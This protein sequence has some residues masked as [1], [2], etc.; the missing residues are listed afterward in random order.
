MNVGLDHLDG[1]R[2]LL[3][4]VVD[5]PDRRRLVQPVVDPQD[6]DPG[7]IVDRGELVVLLARALERR[8]ELDVDLD[9]VTGL[10][11]LVALPPIHVSAVALGGREPV[12]VQ[13]LEDPPHARGAYLEVVVRFRYIEIFRGPK[14]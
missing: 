12:H 13:A 4:H 5:E 8:H 14:W 3:A 1:E 2:E 9:T 10:L 7:A 6:P 11:L